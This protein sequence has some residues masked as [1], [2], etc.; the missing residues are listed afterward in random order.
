ML[1][2]DG[3]RVPPAVRHRLGRERRA[4]AAPAVD[5][6]FALVPDLAQT[7]WAHGSSFGAELDHSGA[8]CGW[9]SARPSTRSRSSTVTRGPV[10][11]R[12]CTMTCTPWPASVRAR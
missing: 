4:D 12:R 6:R 8:W 1:G 10:I 5:H 7:V 11:P 2:V 9:N 3:D